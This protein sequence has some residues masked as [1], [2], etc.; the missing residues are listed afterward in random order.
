MHGWSS[1][2]TLVVQHLD[3]THHTVN[4][5][6]GIRV[7]GPRH[8]QNVKAYHSRLKIWM[9]RFHGVASRYLEN[10]L[11]LRRM[12]EYF[13]PDML[14]TTGLQA[15]LNGARPFQQETAT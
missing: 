9:H 8:I 15:A 6:R 7:R 3:L 12:H 2:D 11:G 5:V 14:P 10:H 1:A 4:L 13:G